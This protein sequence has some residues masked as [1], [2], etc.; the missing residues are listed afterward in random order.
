MNLKRYIALA[1]LVGLLAACGGDATD[2]AAPSTLGEAE[3]NAALGD[4]SSDIISTVLSMNGN[5]SSVALHKF[6]AEATSLLLAGSRAGAEGT[7]PRGRYVYD[8]AANAWQRSGDADDLILT[9][10]YEDLSA[11]TSNEATVTLDWNA[12]GDTVNVAG[13]GGETLELPTA[14]NLMTVAA[15]GE[16]AD[17]DLALSYYNT[18]E[19][20]TAD[21]VAEPTSLQVNGAGSLLDLK[22]VGFTVSE[23]D[24]AETVTTQGEVALNKEGGVTL[25][26]TISLEGERE[27]E[28]CFTST[29]T[30]TSGDVNVS[31]TS[32]AGSFALGVNVDDVDL[33]GGSAALSD[34]TLQINGKLAVSFAGTLDDRNGNGIPGENVTLTFANGQSVTLEQ[35]L[36]S[37]KAGMM[38]RGFHSRR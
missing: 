21:G 14:F 28:N 36:Q 9:W 10:R 2:T 34:G 19:C 33:E 6:P 29:Y 5:T 8:E 35:A 4:L 25:E 12:G 3:T 22:N 11:A 23:A 24:G 17:V 20:G 26:W 27:R 1:L 37:S 32:N 31:V 13:P 16:V 38:M 18:P 7:L 15:G 30:P